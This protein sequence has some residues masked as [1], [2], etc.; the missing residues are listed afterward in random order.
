M[1]QA[2]KEKMQEKT[3]KDQRFMETP[4]T[5]NEGCIAWYSKSSKP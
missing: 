2:I 3:K 5:E 1:N 4:K